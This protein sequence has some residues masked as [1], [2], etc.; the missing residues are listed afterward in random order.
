MERHAAFQN[1]SSAQKK[2]ALELL[3]MVVYIV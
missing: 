1:I 3:H 2:N